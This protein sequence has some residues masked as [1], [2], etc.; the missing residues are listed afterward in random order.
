M[1][2]TET[3]EMIHIIS[4]PGDSTHYDYLV[5]KRG[6]VFHFFTYKNTFK[7]P[8]YIIQGQEDVEFLAD[9]WS[10]NPWTIK[11]CLRTIKELS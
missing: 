5:L 7:Y 6:Y 11:E 10:C 9:E 2:R 1:K 4:E 3:I 8:E